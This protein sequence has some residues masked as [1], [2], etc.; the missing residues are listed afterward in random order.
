MKAIGTVIK[1]YGKPLALFQVKP[2]LLDNPEDISGYREQL[3]HAFTQIPIVLISLKEG[4]L[5]FE[6][7]KEVIE[8]I[9]NDAFE[10][11]HWR[12]YDI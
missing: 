1:K 2:E 3:R 6:G 12:G 11:Y 8:L 4:Q 10:K 9:R 5:V 7:E